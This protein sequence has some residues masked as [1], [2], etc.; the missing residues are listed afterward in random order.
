MTNNLYNELRTLVFELKNTGND[1]ICSDIEQAISF[2]S[3]TTE[4]LMKV[5]FFLLKINK[6]TLSA[7][8]SSKI[9]QL[10]NTLDC[11]LK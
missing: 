2:S 5:R 10:K 8:L 4:T 11:M 3:T 9:D 1:D 6:E 7:D